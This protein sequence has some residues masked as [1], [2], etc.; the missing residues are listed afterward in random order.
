MEIYESTKAAV[1]ESHDKP[2]W[3]P[4]ETLKVHIDSIGGDVKRL[5]DEAA[6]TSEKSPDTAKAVAKAGS[7][8]LEEI[9]DVRG[10][11][12]TGNKLDG[13]WADL[14]QAVHNFRKAL[15][16]HVVAVTGG[17]GCMNGWHLPG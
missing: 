4:S 14:D 15:A 9:E 6:L 3:Q 11:A 12:E 8:V 13:T 17:P 7:K 2:E 10:A 16:E 5:V 1:S